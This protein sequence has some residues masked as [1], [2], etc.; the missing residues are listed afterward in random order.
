MQI[1]ATGITLKLCILPLYCQKDHW[2][3]DLG[4]TLHQECFVPTLIEYCLMVQEKVWKVFIN[5]IIQYLLSLLWKGNFG[6]NAHN[7]I[8]IASGVVLRE[9]LLN[10]KQRQISSEIYIKVSWYSRAKECCRFWDKVTKW[11]YL[12]TVFLI[13][14]WRKVAGNTNEFMLDYPAGRIKAWWI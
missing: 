1:I 6:K 5:N 9:Y 13:Q 3:N 8:P 10:W 14:K 11:M 2:L 12:L 4:S 7:I